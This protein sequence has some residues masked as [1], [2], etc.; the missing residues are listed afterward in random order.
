MPLTRLVVDALGVVTVSLVAFLVLLGLFC[1]IY[2]LYF[3]S[4]IQSPDC[5]EFSYFNGPWIVRIAFVLFAL[6]WGPGEIARLSLLRR[7]GRLF[8][9]LGL[10]W[11]ED[12]CKYYILSNPGFTELCMF[13]IMVFL[14][15]ASLKW[16]DLRILNQK[17]NMKTISYVL[18]YALPFLVLDVIILL[19]SPEFNKGESKMLK[20]HRTFT[21]TYRLLTIPGHPTIVV[22][23]YPL[24]CTIVHGVFTAILTCYLLLLGRRMV[25]SVINKNLS[26]RVW[27]LI[28]VVSILLPLR[29][30]LLGFSVM[31]KAQVHV[32]ALAFLGFLMQLSCILVGMYTL[33][34]LPVADSLALSRGLR[35]SEEGPGG[36]LTEE[37]DD[38]ASLIGAGHGPVSD[39]RDSETSTKRGS[40][41]FRTMIRDEAEASSTAGVFEEEMT[42]F[43]P[44]SNQDLIL[45]A[46]SAGDI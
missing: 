29:D 38:S 13:L 33:V 19:V 23:T 36:S 31:A 30:V 15:G 12:L 9:S 21:S 16:R 43:S 20:L 3:R 10:Q 26:N 28:L 44:G 32:E 2:T 42:T 6:W 41:S 18:L 5:T 24:L 22:C 35:G 7:E 34:Y 40:I 8:S 39:G 14:L 45:S 1:I 17:W 25:S 37:Y 46:S 11:Q 27:T 4:R